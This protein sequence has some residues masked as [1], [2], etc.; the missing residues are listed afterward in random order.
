MRDACAP[1]LVRAPHRAM[2][3]RDGRLLRAVLHET[4][5]LR[6]RARRAALNSVPSLAERRRPI[7]CS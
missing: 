1:L 5:R 6:W 7:N 3:D 4:V 2:R